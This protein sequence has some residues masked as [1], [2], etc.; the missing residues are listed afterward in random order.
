MGMR[1]VSHL[2]IEGY[3]WFFTGFLKL[4]RSDDGLADGRK[5]TT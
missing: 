3:V 1:Y 2:N 5:L 4:Y